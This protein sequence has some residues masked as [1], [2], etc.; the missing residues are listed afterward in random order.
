MV[1]HREE[2]C[3]ALG[4]EA[5]GAS[6]VGFALD[7]GGN[8]RKVEGVRVLCLEETNVSWLTFTGL[9]RQLVCIF[10]STYYK[11]F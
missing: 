4:G 11:F 7:V 5:E 1:E 6:E 8:I 10:K 9:I 2:G 3:V